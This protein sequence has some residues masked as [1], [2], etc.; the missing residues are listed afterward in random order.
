[1]K[2]SFTVKGMPSNGRLSPRASAASAARAASSARSKSRTQ[3][4]LILPSWRSMRAIACS[5]N[6]TAETF[7]RASASDSSVAVAKLHG[8]LVTPF[9]G[10]RCLDRNNAWRR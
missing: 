10:L 7:F 2:D 8:D 9:S 5:A 4:A 6:S 1:L 3:I